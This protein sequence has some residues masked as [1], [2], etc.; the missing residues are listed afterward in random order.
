MKA[1]V[2]STKQEGEG[3]KTHFRYPK[4]SDFLLFK[5]TP[6]FLVDQNQVEIISRA[7]LFVHIAEGWRQVK[8]SEEQT[9]GYS[10][11]C[12]S[13]GEQRTYRIC[14]AIP[15]TGAPFMI[16]NFVI[17][18]LSLYWFGGAPVVSLWI[19]DNSICL[20]FILTSRKK[21]LPTMTSFRWYLEESRL[22]AKK[23]N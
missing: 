10:F 22:S 7:E 15:L 4:N 1:P 9:D 17:V 21:I 12:D 23:R 3:D 18:S 6:I 5:V 14:W 2:S 16:S 11:T 8:A 13:D 20:I 19:I